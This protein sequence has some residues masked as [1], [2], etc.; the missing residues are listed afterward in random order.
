MPGQVN[1]FLFDQSF[2]LLTTTDR[3]KAIIVKA[4]K[5]QK[6][7]VYGANEAQYS[8]DTFL[9]LPPLRAE[10]GDL[11]YI[12]AMAT[13]WLSSDSMIGIVSFE[14]NTVLSITPS[15]TTTIGSALTTAGST[16]QITL[17]KYDSF[18]I[19]QSGDL[20]GTTVI[21]NKPISFITGHHCTNVPPNI[22]AC[23]HLIE[24]LPPIKNWGNRFVTV[25]LKIRLAYDRFKV[26]AGE[27]ATT[28]QI[29]CTRDENP[30]LSTSFTLQEGEFRDVDIPS[31]DYCWIEGDNRIILLQ[32][33]V[34][35]GVDDVLSDPFMAMIPPVNQYSNEYTLTTVPDGV[36]TYTHFMNLYIPKNFF[37]LSEIFLNGQSLEELNLNFVAIQRLGVTEVYGAQVNISGGVQ[38]LRHASKLARIGVIVYGFG[39]F[40]SYGY[41]GGLRLKEL[42]KG[43]WGLER[44]G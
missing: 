35:Q 16:T 24:Q 39:N 2:A 14:N 3:G 22:G 37:Q 42:A 32:F 9:A 13:P 11:K 21:S 25:P 1:S 38:V 28:V 10:S 31:T 12:C 30:G 19:R 36:Q 6:L 26:V 5:D 7:I 33:S 4:S 23:D 8:T 18:L 27:D 20:T 41:P 17:Q 43:I 29:V 34:G 40:N 44:T 15:Q